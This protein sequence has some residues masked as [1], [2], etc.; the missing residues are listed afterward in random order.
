[1]SE[2]VIIYYYY[3]PLGEKLRHL[4]KLSC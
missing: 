4:L 2:W 1:M 3:S